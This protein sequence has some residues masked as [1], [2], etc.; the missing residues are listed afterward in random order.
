M[1]LA[2]RIRF[3]RFLIAF[4]YSAVSGS[5]A[6]IAQPEPWSWRVGAGSDGAWTGVLRE[7][8][9]DCNRLP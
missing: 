1:G 2:Y 9:F 8:G 6:K 7:G 5:G 3:G 4:C